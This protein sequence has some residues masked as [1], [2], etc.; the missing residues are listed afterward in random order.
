MVD[1]A[2]TNL[3]ASTPA[4]QRAELLGADTIKFLAELAANAPPL[5]DAQKD[6]IR[7]AFRGAR[8]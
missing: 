8:D 5:T 6:A 3:S 7:A 4:Q 2:T 1:P